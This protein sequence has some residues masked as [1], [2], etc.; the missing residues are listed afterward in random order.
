MHSL[1][2][3][4]TEAPRYP[5]A[6]RTGTLA[7]T[8]RQAHLR[9]MIH[10][11]ENSCCR[12]TDL[13]RQRMSNHCRVIDSTV[14]PALPR[15]RNWNHKRQRLVNSPARAYTPAQEPS[16]SVAHLLPALILDR[17]HPAA[18]GANVGA[19][20]NH[21]V[22]DSAIELRAAAACR[23]AGLCCFAFAHRIT[24]SRAV[25][26]RGI[27]LPACISDCAFDG[28]KCPADPLLS[29]IIKRWSDSMTKLPGQVPHTHRL[30]RM[31]PSA[32]TE[33]L[34]RAIPQP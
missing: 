3:P 32:T 1:D 11:S 30:P 2:W 4:P 6:A 34:A 18:K 15:H 9:R 33:C 16:Q 23:A 19:E 21:T 5:H 27:G 22:G 28:R 13:P 17:L 20:P 8:G 14:E 12:R 26:A 10:P 29:E 7:F 24:A 31:P 25:V